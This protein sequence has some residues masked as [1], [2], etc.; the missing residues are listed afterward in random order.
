MIM[1]AASF[2]QKDICIGYLPLAHIIE[3]CCELVCMAKGTR[4][5]Y[6]SPN[7]LIDKSTKILP[8]T[9]GDCTELKPTL[10]AC[11]PVSLCIDGVSFIFTLP[12]HLGHHGPY[13]QGHH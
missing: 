10:I 2:R 5:G 12:S 9:K 7:T 8:G 6:S 11:V 4:I 3:V 1:S 13:L